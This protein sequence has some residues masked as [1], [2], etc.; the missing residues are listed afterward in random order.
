MPDIESS[1]LGFLDANLV[2]ENPSEKESF[3]KQTSQHSNHECWLEIAGLLYTGIKGPANKSSAI[4]IWKQLA[5]LD[6]ADAHGPLGE[7]LIRGDDLPLDLESGIFHL[8]R[9]ARLGQIGS[10]RTLISIFKFGFE[11]VAADLE[12]ALEYTK[13]AAELGDIE[14]MLNLSIQLSEAPYFDSASAF[15]YANLAAMAED[16]RGHYNV[17]RAF[18]RGSGIDQDFKKAFFHYDIAARHGI[19]MAQHNLGAL[20][21]NGTGVEQSYEQAKLWYT[22]A[23]VFKSYMSMRN[24]GLMSEEGQLG[25]KSR[26]RALAWYL[27]AHENGDGEVAEKI[28]QLQHEFSPQQTESELTTLKKELTDMEAKLRRELPGWFE[29]GRESDALS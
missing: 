25:D 18:E 8:D 7:L 29:S 26:I 14:Q 13:L 4:A 24:L 6:H 17:G 1:A 2:F 10:A 21:A 22:I 28:E 20:Y 15:H 27:L 9:A 16:P 12:K 3:I 11:G 19:V 23:S 5:D